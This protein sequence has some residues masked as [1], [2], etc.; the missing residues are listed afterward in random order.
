VLLEAAVRAEA[1]VRVDRCAAAPALHCHGRSTRVAEFLPGDQ[2]GA[3]RGA[4]HMTPVRWLARQVNV[5]RGPVQ[6][7]R[8]SAALRASDAPGPRAGL[9]LASAGFWAPG[10]DS[11]RPVQRSRGCPALRASDAPGPRPGLATA[12]AAF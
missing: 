12:S 5:S 2:L 6:C 4:A 10:S 7:S 8:G 9:G 1:K 3:A 11:P